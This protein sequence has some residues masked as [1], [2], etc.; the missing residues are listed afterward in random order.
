MAAS[1]RS[2]INDLGWTSPAVIDPEQ[3][4]D[5]TITPI[6]DHRRFHRPAID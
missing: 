4:D 2:S 5:L 6:T 1:R 3:R